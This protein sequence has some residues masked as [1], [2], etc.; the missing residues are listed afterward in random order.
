ML[1]MTVRHASAIYGDAG[2]PEDDLAELYHEASKVGGV[3]GA[4]DLGGVAR[5]AASE[6]LRASST[7]AVRRHLHAPA[8]ELGPSASLAMPLG[9]ALAA[10]RSARSFATTPLPL[11]ELA[12]LLR[13][14]YGITGELRAGDGVQPL[15]AAPSGGALYPLELTVGARH[16]E[17]LEPGLYHFDPLDDALEKVREGPVAIAATTPFADIAAEAAAVIVVSAVFW[18]SRFK[19]GLRGYRFA[20]LEAG[21]VAQNIL[22]AA[23]ALELASVPLGG[24]YDRRV[25]EVLGVN[26]VDESALYLLCVGLPEPP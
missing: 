13:A 4:A 17:G 11:R 20:L 6:D 14:G 21:H 9:K 19:Y 7:R 5:L 23:A 3:T 24:F 10:R 25:D 12:A 22:L 26:G 15:R 1:R 2:P 18:R 8:V 16:V